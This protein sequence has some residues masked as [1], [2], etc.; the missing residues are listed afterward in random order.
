MNAPLVNQMDFLF[1][2]ELIVDNFAGGGGASTGM[3]WAIGRSP[4]IA[5]NHDPQAVAMHKA[6]HPNTKHYCEDVWDID[7][8][9]ACMGRAVGLAWFSP[10]CKHH[11][12]ARGCKPVSKKIRGLAWVVVRWAKTVRPRVIMLENVEEFQDWGPTIPKMCDEGKPIYKNGEPVLVP[13]P[14]RKGETFNK[15]VSELRALGYKVEWDELLASDFGAPTDRNRLFLVARCDGLPI[16]WPSRTHTDH[17]KKRARGEKK[18]APKPIVADC[19][20]W[21]IPVPSIFLTKEEGKALRVKRPLVDKTM[22]RIA[23]GVKK[24][25]IDADE[26]FTV[27]SSVIPFVTEHANGSSQRNMPGDEPMRTICAET[28][29][30]HFALVAAFITKHYGGNYEG[31]GISMREPT[32]TITT[33]DHHGLVGCQLVPSTGK[34]KHHSKD[35]WAFL[36]KYYGTDQNPSLTKPLHTI[37]TKDRF[38][39]ITVEG[40]DYMLTDIG[41]RMFTARELYR[42]QGFP[43]SYIIDFI[44]EGKPLTITAQKRMVGNSV[45]PYPA[46]AL[47]KANV[48]VSKTETL[49]RTA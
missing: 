6:N 30:G 22:A 31:A 40:Q 29:G 2:E 28:K 38:A 17:S 26:P 35:V 47:V 7:P 43:D 46:M 18:L 14:D 32:D 37:T 8:I 49:R 15:W 25:V 19:I 34:D 42:A 3:E 21:G 33:V 41:A 39:L 24:Y 9:K 12:K 13:C 36:I 1:T 20:D 10:D 5:I 48:G 23:R 27:Q 11:S 4:D 16:K 44:F 45:S